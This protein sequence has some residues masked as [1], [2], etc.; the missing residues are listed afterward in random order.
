MRKKRENVS[1]AVN[2]LLGCP[3]LLSGGQ[4]QRGMRRRDGLGIRYSGKIRNL[5]G[6]KHEMFGVLRW[7]APD[8]C[9]LAAEAYAVAIREHRQA[10][11][12]S[13]A[14]LSARTNMTRAALSRIEN[15]LNVNPTVETL[16]RIGEALGL[17]LI[18]DYAA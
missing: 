2:K 13:L 1:P 4:L 10:Q 11:G 12:V 17:R 8:W 5:F 15:G 6:T 14:E 9:A 7:A 18:V 16:R 3:P